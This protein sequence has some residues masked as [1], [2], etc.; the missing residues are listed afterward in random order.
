MKN[1]VVSM[2]CLISDD[3]GLWHLATG[4]YHVPHHYWRLG[5]YSD[6]NI[7]THLYTHYINTSE[8]LDLHAERKKIY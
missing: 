4:I 5:L 6:T 1:P 2:C 7:H 3:V 8:L